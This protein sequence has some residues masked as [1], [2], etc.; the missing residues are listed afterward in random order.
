MSSPTAA[1]VQ[2][3]AKH[4]APPN[5]RA[6]AAAVIAHADRAALATFTASGTPFGSLVAV[7]THSELDVRFALAQACEHVDNLERDPR[8]TVL[9]TR[10]GPGADGPSKVAL[11]GRARVSGRDATGNLIYRLALDSVRLTV[12]GSVFSVRFDG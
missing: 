3:A 4:L 5:A 11:S 9:L 7:E 10:S 6:A 12:A 1:C 8:A 2:P